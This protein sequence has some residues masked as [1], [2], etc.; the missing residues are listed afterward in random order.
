[1]KLA[2]ELMIIQI[3]KLNL[4]ETIAAELARLEIETERAFS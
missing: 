3:V 4:A 1:M 2:N